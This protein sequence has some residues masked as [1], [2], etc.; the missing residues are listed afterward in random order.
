M[1]LI[2]VSHRYTGRKVNEIESNGGGGGGVTLKLLEDASALHQ[3]HRHRVWHLLHEFLRIDMD[4]QH[5][6]NTQ[7]S[8]QVEKFLSR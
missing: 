8:L 5:P 2:A 7:A 4:G 6:M 3:T 1:E